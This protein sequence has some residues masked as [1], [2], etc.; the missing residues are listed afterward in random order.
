MMFIVILSLF[1]ALPD[2]EENEIK[3]KKRH[4]FYVANEVSSAIL[5]LGAL[6]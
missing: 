4:K 2:C 6:W 1:K 5:L 3:K